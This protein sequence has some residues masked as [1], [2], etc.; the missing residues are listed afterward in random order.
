MYADPGSPWPDADRPGRLQG[1]LRDRH[2]STDRPRARSNAR[3]VAWNVLLPYCDGD[4]SDLEGVR[5]FDR[6]LRTRAEQ[7][8]LPKST[9]AV[10]GANHNFYN[11]EWQRSD[12]LGC[13]GRRQPASVRDSGGSADQ[14]QTALSQPG[15]VHARMSARTARP[16]LAN[17]FD[18]ATPLP[19]ALAAITRVDRG[20][21]DAS[22]QRRGRRDRGFR[23]RPGTGSSGRPHWSRASGSSMSP[24]G[25]RSA[26]Q[27]GRGITWSG[28]G[29]HISQTNWTAAG[30]GRS[31]AGL[32]ARVSGLP[33]M[34]RL[35]L[36][37]DP[38]TSATATDFSVQLVRPDGSL[39]RG[40]P[41]P[42]YV[43]CAGRSGGGDGF[44]PPDPAD[45]AH[46]LRD[47]GSTRRTR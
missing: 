31:L 23:R 20:F 41:C 4:V 25:A 39:S 24:R 18:P 33:A 37:V 38:P 29:S 26:L 16:A 32:H 11:T 6:M 30:A 44:R 19:A 35:V 10:Y 22:D 21:S 47:S 5:P 13:S 8:T 1:T 12:A 42:A 40:G 2:R 27:R 34:R 3:G 9:F 36:T 15:A 14:R 28:T 45:G 43:S 17:L 46:S 7:P